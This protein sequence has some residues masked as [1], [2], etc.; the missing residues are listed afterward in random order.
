MSAT[1]SDTNG[2]ASVQFEV[3]G[4][5]V[6]PAETV[7]P[8]QYTWD[9]T[10]VANGIHTVT[11]IATN[12][13]NVST[14]SGGVSINVDNVVPV[15]T[16]IVPNPLVETANATSSSL[17]LDWQTGGWGTN[18][19]TF[20]YLKTGS[21]GDTNSINV[22]TTAYTS[23]DSKW[24]FNPVSVV[25]GQVYSFSDYYESTIAT[26][27]Y[28]AYTLSNG[29]MEYISLGTA[30]VSSSWAKFSTSITIPTGVASATIYHVIAGVGSLT[31]DD[32]SLATS[33]APSVTITSPTAS[34]ATSTPISGSISLQANASDNDGVKNVQFQVDGTNVGPTETVA[35]YSYLWN[36]ASTADGTHNITAIVT[37]NDGQ[38]ATSTAVSIEVSNT[39]PL[40]GNL[41]PNPLMETV[42]SPSHHRIH[43]QVVQSAIQDV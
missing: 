26:Q 34:T 28:V 13:D 32:F 31:T 22:K 9:S 25:P 6:G 11:A 15:G 16:N 36:S 37:G 39:K 19:T 27:L 4:S 35:P 30:P 18:T 33:T 43:L 38:S 29:T 2:I 14:T 8:Y 3:D 7:A 10:T 42:S 24:Y 12:V 21:A 23:G 17:P 40:G 1:A 5:N 20:S 41:V